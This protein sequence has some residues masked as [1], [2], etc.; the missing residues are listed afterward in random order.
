MKRLYA[1]PVFGLLL[2]SGCDNA[3]PV[4]HNGEV[5]APIR[6]YAGATVKDNQCWVNEKLVPWRRDPDGFYVC[7]GPSDSV[8]I[9]RP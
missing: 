1:A 8:E 6:A 9:K 7:G 4:N 3:E 5:V 2:L